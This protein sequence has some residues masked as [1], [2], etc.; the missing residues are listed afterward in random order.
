MSPSNF[1]LT[2][3]EVVRATIESGG[4]NLINGLKNMLD[5]L[6]RGKGKLNIRMTDLN[7]FELGKNIATTPGK[8][9]YPE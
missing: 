4:Q 1:A 2:N 3:P 9:I 5:D 8:V 6:E 7:A